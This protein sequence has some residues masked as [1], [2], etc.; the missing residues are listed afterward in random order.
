LTSFITLLRFNRN[1]RNLWLGQ[2]VS[3]AGD[4]F[5]TI[6]VLSMALRV[7]ESGFAVGGVML[8]RTISSIAAAPLAGV[9]LDR[10]DRKKIMV[11]SD[12]IRGVVALGFLLTLHYPASWLLYLL[13]SLLTFSSP[14]FTSGRSAIL[15]RITTA[16]ELHTANAL[17]QTTAW[18]TLSIGTMLGGMSAMKFGYAWAFVINAASFL[19]S[20]VAV[21]RLEARTGHFRPHPRRGEMAPDKHFWTDHLEGLGYVWRTPLIFAIGMAGV[22]WATGGGAAQIL[23]ALYGEVVF[24]RGPAGVGWIWGSAGLGLVAGGFFSHRLSRTLGFRGYKNAITLLF[25][26]HGLSYIFFSQAPTL[27]WAIVFIVLSRIGMGANNVLNRNMLLTHV[28]DHYRGRVFTT[29]ESMLQVTMLLSLTAASVATKYVDPRDIGLVAGCLST[30]TAFFWAWANWTGKL[31]EPAPE[32]I[33]A[34][35]EQFNE[36]LTPA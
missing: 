11:A 27:A 31:V 6:A 8:A 35:E 2:I 36:P 25:L 23:F 22:G 28:P 18:L 32:P 10:W 34:Q 24:D 26:L 33:E 13:S 12:V 21:S 14:F 4:H 17:T 29:V 1:Y 15:P 19:L 9:L 20:A 7:D 30:S 16:D 3:E 5:N